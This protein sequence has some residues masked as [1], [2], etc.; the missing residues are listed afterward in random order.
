MTTKRLSVKAS[1]VAAIC[2]IGLASGLPTA[3]AQTAQ[4]YD[5]SGVLG[6]VGQPGGGGGSPSPSGV[7]AVSS[8][9]SGALPFT[10]LDMGILLALG[11][12][13]AGTG[14]VLRRATRRPTQY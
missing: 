13:A 6:D 5:E 14:L 2:A 9:S 10:G 3:S 8:D 11:G 7:N 12:A 1:L 4:G